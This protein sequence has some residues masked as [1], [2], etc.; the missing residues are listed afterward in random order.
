MENWIVKIQSPIQKTGKEMF[1]YRKTPIGQ[2]TV[3]NPSTKTEL[4]LSQGQDIPEEFILYFPDESL[5]DAVFDSLQSK[6]FKP[7][8]QSFVE[9]KLESQS[10]HL[11]D[12][13]K[14]LKL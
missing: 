1:I 12:L 8:E 14:L 9:G 11:Q 2:V 5:L 3:Y 7:K 4:T 13:R 10:E 6:G